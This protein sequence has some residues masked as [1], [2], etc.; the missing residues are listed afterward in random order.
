MK[1]PSQLAPRGV[2]ILHP[3]THHPTSFALRSSRSSREIPILSLGKKCGTVQRFRSMDGS[4]LS[5]WALSRWRLLIIR[6]ATSST[7]FYVSETEYNAVSISACFFLFIFVSN[8][9]VG[10]SQ[11]K[12]KLCSK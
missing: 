5:R 12:K 8:A 7:Y 4:V 3:P 1:R 9:I 11:E 2:P 6:I 10:S